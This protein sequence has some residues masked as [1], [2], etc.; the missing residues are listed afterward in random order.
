LVFEHRL[1]FPESFCRAV[2]DA[3]L[4]VMMNFAATIKKMSRV[5]SINLFFAKIGCHA[6][7]LQQ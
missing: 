6:A 4:F 2:I 3:V 1:G 5:C 7:V